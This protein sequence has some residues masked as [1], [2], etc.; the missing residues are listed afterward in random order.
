MREPIVLRRQCSLS[1]WN[2]RTTY[3]RPPGADMDLDAIRHEQVEEND[4]HM[5]LAIRYEAR[6]Q[7]GQCNAKER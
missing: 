2:S 6:Q 4:S 3:L 7:R 5:P 1:K